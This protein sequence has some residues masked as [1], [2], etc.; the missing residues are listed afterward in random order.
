M[1]ESIL[2]GLLQNTA[3]LLAFSLLYQNIWIKDK[4][5]KSTSA[6]ILAGLIL[7]GIGVILMFT[8]WMLIP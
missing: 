2:I 8:P 3:I 4:D 7:G 5:A 1:K 6:K